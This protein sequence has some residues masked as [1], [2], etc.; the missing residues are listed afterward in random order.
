MYSASINTIANQIGTLHFVGIG[1]IGMSGIAELLHNMGCKVQG[2]D[3]SSNSNIFRL[4]KLGIK[5]FIGHQPENIKDTNVVVKSAAVKEDNIEIVTAIEEHIP[6]ISR[7]QMLAEIMRFKI[8]IAISGTHGKTTT[9]SLTASVFENAGLKPTVVNGGIINSRSTNAYLGQSDYLIAEADESDRSF[10]SLI[11]T[12]VVVTNIDPDH[13]E[14]YDDMDHMKQEY[15][16]FI[17]NIPFYGFAVLC[18]DHPVVADITRN[19]KDRHY[20]TYGFSNEANI[21]ALNVR[22]E[23]NGSYFDVN[24]NGKPLIKDVFLPLLGEHNVQNSLAAIALAYKLGLYKNL[25]DYSALFEGFCGVKRRFTYV[26]EVKGCKIFDD[27][28]HHP[29]EIKATLK[30]A[31]QLRNGNQMNKIIVVIQPHRYSRLM[32]LFEEF[33]QAFDN[34]DQL[35]IMPVYTAG[36]AEIIGYNHQSLAQKIKTNYP[37]LIVNIA[38]GESELAE[39]INSETHLNDLLLFLGAG[40][41]T[42]FAYNLYEKNMNLA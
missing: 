20:I 12:I 19:L 35:I 2:S 39:I 37:D 10:T 40:S 25:E 30:A 5:V 34:I 14:N 22:L 38:E 4:Q 13:L 28:A 8:S 24:I 16:K 27:Y 31:N 6:V 7:A 29:V 11:A 17:H 15:L 41:I 42:K 23:K 33:S 18:I 26:G 36:E 3:I 21:Q 32:N 1:G 9:T